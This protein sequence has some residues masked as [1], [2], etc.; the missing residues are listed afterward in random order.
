[1]EAATG[2]EGAWIQKCMIEEECHEKQYETA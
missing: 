2:A 1:M